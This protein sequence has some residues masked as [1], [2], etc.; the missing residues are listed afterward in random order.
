MHGNEEILVEGVRAL[1]PPLDLPMEIAA[2]GSAKWI[3]EPTETSTW[4]KGY[5]YVTNSAPFLRYEKLSQIIQT[6]VK[7]QEKMNCCAT[8]E[9][10]K[11]MCTNE[12][13]YSLW[14]KV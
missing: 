12:L 1:A 14:V 10:M 3:A 11:N 7:L 5:K 2:S 13:K 4:K 8:N 6:R 9:G